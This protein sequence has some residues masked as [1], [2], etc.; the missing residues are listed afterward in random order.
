M[1]KSLRESQLEVNNDFG[2]TSILYTSINILGICRHSSAGRAADFKS[3]AALL[4][5][6]RSS[7]CLMEYREHLE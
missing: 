7:I 1:P 6:V 5:Y 3:G 2:E 4:E